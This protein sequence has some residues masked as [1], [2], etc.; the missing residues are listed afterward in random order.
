[1]GYFV[2]IEIIDDVLSFHGVFWM[3]KSPQAGFVA[4]DEAPK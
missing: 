1:M 3:C 2:F 4:Y